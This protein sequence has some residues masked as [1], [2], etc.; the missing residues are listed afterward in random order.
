MI[1]GYRERIGTVAKDYI[2]I[3]KHKR[4]RLNIDNQQF[5]QVLKITFKSTSICRH[6]YNHYFVKH[7]I[8]FFKILNDFFISLC[9]Q[10]ASRVFF[11][12]DNF[13]LEKSCF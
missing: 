10:F 1:R 13:F 7:P 11:R 9:K 4:L 6:I 5:S 3:V 12:L 2:E 8:G